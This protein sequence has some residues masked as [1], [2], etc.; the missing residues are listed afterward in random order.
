MYYIGLKVEEFNAHAEQYKVNMIH[1]PNVGSM[2]GQRRRW[3]AS[4]EPTLIA[5][6]VSADIG[7]L[8]CEG[9]H[10]QLLLFG[11]AGI[12]KVTYIATKSI[13][14]IVRPRTYIKILYITK[15]GSLYTHTVTIRSL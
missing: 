5:Y 7:L 15:A 2:L 11:F 6:I 9:K 4:I 14:T 13:T 12:N 1:S 3:W 10:K 8:Q